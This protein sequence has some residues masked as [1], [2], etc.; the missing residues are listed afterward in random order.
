[1]RTVNWE[2]SNTF[3]SSDE[4]QVFKIEERDIFYSFINLLD[5]GGIAH[6]KDV[7]HYY[8]VT[9]CVAP[10]TYERGP[11]D[12]RSLLIVPAV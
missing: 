9:G 4:K 7:L 12:L 1:M 6:S 2:S 5:V 10:I 8:A 11:A 3:C